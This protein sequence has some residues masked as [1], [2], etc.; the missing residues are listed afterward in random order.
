[1]ILGNHE[2]YNETYASAVEK[3][4]LLE[5]EDCFEG[6][7]VVLDRR[8][9]DVPDS[10]ISILGC[11]LWSRISEEARDVVQ[12]KVEDFQKIKDRT[13]VQHNASHDA[14]LAWLQSEIHSIQQLNKP[15]QKKGRRSILVVTRHAP[16]LE[17]T[18]SPQHVQSPWR[19]AFGTDILS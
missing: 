2:F 13:V 16:S 5:R 1:M 9:F 6:R 17:R 12:A 10:G 7:L 18:S 11:T 15:L 4:R 19:S 8:R 3:A 14:D